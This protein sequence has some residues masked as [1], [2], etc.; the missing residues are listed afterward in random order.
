MPAA[1]KHP[2]GKNDKGFPV[3]FVRYVKANHFL[4]QEISP[5]RGEPSQLRANRPR[6]ASFLVLVAGADP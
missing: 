3:S 1:V 2:R 5:E 6:L 4:R